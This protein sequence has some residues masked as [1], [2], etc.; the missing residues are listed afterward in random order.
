MWRRSSQFKRA[1]G[2]AVLSLGKPSRLSG[3]AAITWNL[4]RTIAMLFGSAV[5]LLRLA[6]QLHRGVG[7]YSFR[8]NA[9]R[10]GRRQS[11]GVTKSSNREHGRTRRCSGLASL[12][13]EL[14][15]WV[16]QAHVA[17]LLS[18]RTLAQCR[19]RL[20][21][22]PQET[23]CRRARVTFRDFVRLRGKNQPS[24]G[25]FRCI[26]CASVGRRHQRRKCRANRSHA[27]YRSLPPQTEVR[28]FAPG[29]TRESRRG[30]C[31]GIRWRQG[32]RAQRRAPPNKALQLT[33]FARS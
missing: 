25:A 10:N 22:R 30:Y 24:F 27:S 3:S 31:V 14:I 13:A 8:S 29:R 11:R 23:G 26:T 33:R 32:L 20:F 7:L 15:R 28:C 2:S 16:V 5:L 6:A 21:D 19:E 18:I 12:V 4:C 17:P 9:E 1:Q